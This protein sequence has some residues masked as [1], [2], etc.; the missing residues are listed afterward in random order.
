MPLRPYQFL[1]MSHSRWTLNSASTQPVSMFVPLPSPQ[2]SSVPVSTRLAGVVAARDARARG[3]GHRERR[4]GAAGVDRERVGPL[5]QP[6]PVPSTT[7]SRRRED[8]AGGGVGDHV[9]PARDR[10]AVAGD[11]ASR[12]RASACPSVASTTRSVLSTPSTVPASLRRRGL[13]GLRLGDAR[14]GRDVDG[15]VLGD[16]GRRDLAVGLGD[17]HEVAADDRQALVAALVRHVLQAVL[18]RD[19]LLLMERV[20]RAR[21]ELR[22]D[23]SSRSRRPCR[24]PG[25][26]SS[27]PERS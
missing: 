13:R 21:V 26:G 4:A 17:D 14:G 22:R 19:D 10:A 6:V 9:Q 1:S 23:G 2:T 18:G 7:S 24:P 3:V 20:R 25:G 12:R 8:R 15:L 5:I 16:G 11:D 27:P